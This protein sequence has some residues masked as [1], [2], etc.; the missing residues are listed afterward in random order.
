MSDRDELAKVICDA[1]EDDAS[2][3]PYDVRAADAVI[4]AGWRKK[5]SATEVREWVSANFVVSNG[6]QV[7]V[8]FQGSVDGFTD[9]IL[10]LLEGPTETGEK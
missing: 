5:P 7:W 4:V 9:A 8:E 1:C 6:T 3:I 10:A 2:V